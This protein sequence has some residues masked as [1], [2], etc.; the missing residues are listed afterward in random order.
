[1]LCSRIEENLYLAKEVL[2]VSRQK[3]KEDRR[4]TPSKPR[5]AMPRLTN[6]SFVLPYDDSVNL[7]LDAAKE[8]FNSETNL[9]GPSMDLSK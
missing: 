7:I 8:Y 9:T 6:S 5:K 3:P 4:S 1:M 2:T